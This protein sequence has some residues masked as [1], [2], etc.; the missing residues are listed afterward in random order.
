[1]SAGRVVGKEP[2]E[3]ECRSYMVLYVGYYS[4]IE[5][6]C[7]VCEE[8]PQYL[9]YMLFYIVDLFIFT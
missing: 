7:R 2:R 6:H 1:M 5:S 8:E 9:T 4:E 3:R